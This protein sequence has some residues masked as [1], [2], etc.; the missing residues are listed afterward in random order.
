M[1]QPKSYRILMGTATPNPLNIGLFG[2]GTVG[3]GFYEIIEKTNKDFLH[4]IG[5]NSVIS[6]ICVR[7]VKKPRDF[8]IMPHTTLVSDYKDILEDETINCV[9][10]LMGGVTDAKDVVFEAIKR[11][12]HVVTANK[13]LLARFLP[14]IQQLLKENPGVEFGYEAAVC[15][16]IP[17]INA[18]Q[19]DYFG[20]NITKICGIMNGTTNFMLSKME[21]EGAA[22]EDVLKEAQDLGYAEA[23]PT[24]DVEGHDVQ[25]KIALL[26]KLAFGATVPV[27]SVPCQGISKLTSIDF[28]FAK[29][30]K[31][32]IKLLG[33]AILSP[34]KQK[35]S[36]FVSPVI[37]PLSSL[38]AGTRGA[39]NI[40]L[41]NSK[42]LDTSSYSGPGAGRFPTANSVVSDVVRLSKG[43]STPPFPFDRD[44]ELEKDFTGSFY[45]RITCRDELGIIKRVG[46]LAEENGVSIHAIHQ[47]PIE[48]F[49]NVDFVVT[50]E[51]CHLSQVDKLCDSISKETWSKNR[52]LCL[53]LL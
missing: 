10:E 43:Y 32:T 53:S 24:A 9:V 51:E 19:N 25:A 16:G 40:I 42:N 15:G 39:S 36:V 35:L 26:T 20:D 33:T 18:L 27:S 2:G 47:N 14:E 28:E 31:S 21:S 41:I 37:V 5:S 23:D 50:T 17:I 3:G 8:E 30:M 38:I 46:G 4:G 44:W 45:L 29:M 52:P 12:K 7:D 22:Y 49:E 34:D 48:D 1:S 11:K 6:K 13:A